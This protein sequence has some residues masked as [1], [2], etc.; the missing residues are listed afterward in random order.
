[1]RCVAAPG[2]AGR[3][4]DETLGGVDGG[5]SGD[6]VLVGDETAAAL[7]LKEVVGED[8]LLRERPIR[9]DL[10]RIDVAIRIL[11]RLDVLAVDV[12]Q[13][14]SVHFARTS[15]QIAISLISGVVVVDVLGYE[16]GFRQRDHL[17]RM[18]RA[19][20]RPV[21]VWK[22]REQIVE[23]AILLNDEYDML[24]AGARFGMQSVRRRDGV[25]NW[26]E[27]CRTARACSQ[28]ER[29]CR[30]GKGNGSR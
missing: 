16:R 23:A 30:D 14:E 17:T 19:L 8:V 26:R 27:Y 20:R 21:G 18:Q 12:R 24:N 25:G 11:L 9:R 15:L 22:R 1:G 3:N 28:G 10:R 7:G 2:R 5:S 6:E 13:I 4:V 29:R